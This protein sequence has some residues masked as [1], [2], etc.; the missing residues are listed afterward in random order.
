MTMTEAVQEEHTLKNYRPSKEALEYAEKLRETYQNVVMRRACLDAMMPRERQVELYNSMMQQSPASYADNLAYAFR[1]GVIRG[2]ED[3]GDNRAV[4][5]IEEIHAAARNVLDK[6][7]EDFVVRT[8][9]LLTR[10]EITARMSNG[11]KKIRFPA[12]VEIPV[13]FD[14][15]SYIGGIFFLDDVGMSLEEGLRECLQHTI[16]DWLMG[17]PGVSNSLNRP[18]KSLP[19]EIIHED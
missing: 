2:L 17:I 16:D 13:D 11:M 12:P 1:K 7:R 3:Y 8:R 4:P 10:E 15:Y 18:R 14:E 19:I 6:E 5:S 9:A